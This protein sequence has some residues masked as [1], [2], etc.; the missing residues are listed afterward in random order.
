[1]GVPHQYKDL[2][3]IGQ[4][5]WTLLVPEKKQHYIIILNLFI[6]KNILQ[7]N[8]QVKTC[9]VHYKNKNNRAL[10]NLTTY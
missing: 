4:T 8:Y 7:E 5:E 3:R 1:M 6:T 10:I 9:L 2:K